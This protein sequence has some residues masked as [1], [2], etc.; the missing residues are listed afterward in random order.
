MAVLGEITVHASSRA[1]ISNSGTVQGAGITGMVSKRAELATTGSPVCKECGNPISEA[2]D[3]CWTCGATPGRDKDPRVDPGGRNAD[4]SH[5]ASH[6]S[7]KE[8][9]EKSTWGRAA[10]TGVF[11]DPSEVPM[12]ELQRRVK[13]SRARNMM[14]SGPAKLHRKMPKPLLIAAL[15]L[16][17]LLIVAG[18][19]QRV[20]EHALMKSLRFAVANRVA[21]GYVPPCVTY[22]RC[23]LG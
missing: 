2:N 6:L 8:S 18:Y 10:I 16:L 3:F 5:Y 12:E 23:E 21:R 15:V 1:R 19:W 20:S 17:A 14:H 7:D 11:R 22:P 9:V 13:P 4:P